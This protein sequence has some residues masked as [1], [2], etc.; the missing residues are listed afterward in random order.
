MSEQQSEETI[1]VV[2][3]PEAERYEAHVNGVLAGRAEYLRGAG[4][5]SFTHTEVDP[6]FGGRGLAGRLAQKALDDA[7]ASGLE[8]LPF[9]PFF[10]DWIQ[11][12]PDYAALVPANRRAEFGL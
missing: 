11:K 5:I 3:H 7:K 4:Q 10:R 9:C 8:V 6:A 1:E 12:H 2:D